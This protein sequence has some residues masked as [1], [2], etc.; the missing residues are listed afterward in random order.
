[1]VRV[2]EH[3]DDARPADALRI[4]E[5]G[6][7]EAALLELIHAKTP[8]PNHVFLGAEMQ[9][10]GWTGLD[11]GG[12]E[13]HRNAVHAERAL[14]HLPGLRPEARHVERAARLAIAAALSLI[15][16]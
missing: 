1:M 5:R 4:V 14:R 11:T 6:G 8:Q 7:R 10:P 16:I 2:R 13:A 9:A 3:R 15:H 12:F